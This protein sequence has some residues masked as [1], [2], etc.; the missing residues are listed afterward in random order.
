MDAR[1]RA[2]AR[3]YRCGLGS[4]GGAQTGPRFKIRPMQSSDS[5]SCFLFFHP[6]H[7]PPQTQQDGFNLTAQISDRRSIVRRPGETARSSNLPLKTCGGATFPSYAADL[8]RDP[9]H[10]VSQQNEF[11]SGLYTRLA[12][13]AGEESTLNNHLIESTAGTI[14]QLKDKKVKTA[15]KRELNTA[16]ASLADGRGSWRAPVIQLLGGR[17]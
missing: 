14:S 9:P 11:S 15:D 4:L 7:S 1:A 10:P 2:R 17:V 5:C 12:K 13:P 3:C 8:H 6:P 16:S